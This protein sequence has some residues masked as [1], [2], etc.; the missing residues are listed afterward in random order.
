MARGLKTRLLT[1]KIQQFTIF[2][3]FILNKPTF[4]SAYKPFIFEDFCC[5]ASDKLQVFK[6]YKANWVW[7]LF[8][9]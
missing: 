7:L 3:Q 5:L 9:I 1:F 8:T 4:L 6:S 2:V